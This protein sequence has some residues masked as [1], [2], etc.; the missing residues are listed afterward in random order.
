M[1]TK[2]RQNGLNSVQLLLV[3]VTMGC[4]LCFATGM[5]RSSR[6]FDGLITGGLDFGGA[7]SKTFS[8]AQGTQ[9]G[10]LNSGP[11]YS[12]PAGSYTLTWTTECDAPNRIRL[13][14]SNGAR[15]EPQEMVIHPDRWTDSA[16]FTLL[17]DAENLQIQ[18]CFEAGNV[19]KLHDVQ[20]SF[21]C[22]DGLWAATLLL[23]G[24][25]VLYGL[26]ARGLLTQERKQALVI[27]LAVVLAA[28]VPALRENLNAGHDSE[29][30]RMRLRNLVS[31]LSEGQ[32]P[33]RV[34]GYMYNGYGGAA[35][36]FYPDACLYLPALLMLGGATIQFALSAMIVAV[37]AIT[38]A[39]TYACGKRMFG[40]R[41]AGLGVSIL[42]TLA[43]YRLTDIYT[44]MAIG[45]AAAMAVIPLFLL[46]LW[47]VVFGEKRRWPLL[48]LGATAVFQTH[49]ISTVL[50]AVLAAALCAAC[51]MR[52]IREKR[53]GA[54]LLAIAVTVLLNL[55]ALVPLLDYMFGGISMGTLNSS[56][57][58][59]AM[60]LHELFAQ[61][62]QFPRDIGAALFVGAAAAAYALAGKKTGEAKM[63]R[64]LLLAGA[65]AALMATELFPWA[66]IEKRFGFAINFLQFPWRLLMFA[67]IFL[68]LACGYG[69][70]LL[71]DAES[72]K[73][74][75]VLLVLALSVIASSS[76]IQTYAI[77]EEHA[78]RY[79]LSN[80]EM[81][82]AY[83]EYTL[84]GT[85]VG[86]TVYEHELLL[87]GDV[88]VASYEKKG[89]RVAAEVSAQQGGSLTLPV[90]GFDGYAAEMNGERLG[91]TL[92]DNNRLTVQI[93]AGASGSLRIWFAG[94]PI[95][96]I[97]DAVSLA[98]AI[99]LCA[100]LLR[101]RKNELPK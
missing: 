48:V 93:P 28:S 71:S 24:L 82:T 94:K 84:P 11:N 2:G 5:G 77:Q 78:D 56:V 75:G 55:F 87:A 15:I 32:F 72:W 70:T 81:I 35:S 45:E 68:A 89:T 69:L 33:V 60:K 76:Q 100:Y 67:D 29:F 97:A 101:R 74:S 83:G 41:M 63:A 54:L 31:A 92:G 6:V 36:V 46:G 49:M 43:A 90:F 14:S 51:M 27:L 37:N 38:A 30:H 53:L 7:Q 40:S 10:V 58:A 44:R 13:T 99:A 12:L 20:L 25:W 91:W 88:Q 61:N 26:N 50:C 95:W 19:L 18:F 21:A 64:A 42:Y 8:L 59:G 23:I 98:T 86:R 47:E 62:A 57:S 52:L 16:V 73:R 22:T 3:I 85:D 65:I 79:W 4:A 17:D 66:L 34:G 80:S 1:T 39:T 9:Y 96:R